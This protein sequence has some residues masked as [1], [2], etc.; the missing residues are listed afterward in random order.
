M[1]I[2]SLAPSSSSLSSM[3]SNF[4]GSKSNPYILHVDSNY[5]ERNREFDIHH[6]DTIEH[7]DFHRSGYNIR[8]KTY[9]TDVPFWSAQM[10]NGI[11]DHEDRAILVK[12]PSRDATHDLID[13]YHRKLDCAHTKD[14]HSKTSIAISQAPERQVSYWLLL[15]KEGVK[16][17]N[18]VFS[19]DN[20]LV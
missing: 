10:Q 18:V 17:D 13:E 6:M 19:G 5:P 9:I 20:Q 12:G 14:A 2:P 7:G 15:F 16:L 1:D 8:V 4:A 11:P 3:H